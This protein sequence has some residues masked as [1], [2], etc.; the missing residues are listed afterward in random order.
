MS[1]VYVVR[2]ILGGDFDSVMDQV[3]VAEGLQAKQVWW[4]LNDIPFRVLN[5]KKRGRLKTI[6][7]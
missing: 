1:Y 3:S 7:G 4:E 2:Q 5:L 6:L